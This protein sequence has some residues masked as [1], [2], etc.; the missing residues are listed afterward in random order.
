MRRYRRRYSAPRRRS[1]GV[2]YRFVSVF[3]TNTISIPVNGTDVISLLTPAGFATA[4]ITKKAKIAS[5]QGHINIALATSFPL[6]TAASIDPFGARFAVGIYVDTGLVGATNANS[7][8]QQ[9]YSLDWMWWKSGS[10]NT[11]RVCSGAGSPQSVADSYA[12][13]RLTL[14]TRK[15]TRNIDPSDDTL[16]MPVQNSAQST[17]P[18]AY[19]YNFRILILE[20]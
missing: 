18:I 3:N 10:V 7:P 19:D 6:C 17:S 4:G 16:V 14:A 20:P 13:Q 1:S 15:Y 9:A 2:G 5:I 11:S 8:L 12:V